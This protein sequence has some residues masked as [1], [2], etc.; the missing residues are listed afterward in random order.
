MI[1]H[2]DLALEFRKAVFRKLDTGEELQ[3]DF[4]A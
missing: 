2:S 3:L 1:L 4:N